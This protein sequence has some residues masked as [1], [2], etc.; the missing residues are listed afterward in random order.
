MSK[1]I[2]A[3]VK[4]LEDP[5][6]LTG[7][8]TY[9]DDLRPVPNIHHAAILRS[10]H[11]HARIL[12][13]DVSKALAMPGVVGVLTPQDVLELSDP[14]PVGVEAP[15]K[16]YATATDKVRFVG[17][18]VCVV[19]AR[20]RYIAEDARE[21]IEV[22][23]EP[24]PAV[25]DPEKAM[26]PGAPLLHEHIGSN[27]ACYRSLRYGDPDGAFARA[28]VVVSQRQVFPKYGSTPMECYGVIATY[29]PISQ[30][31]TVWSNFQGPFS[32]HPVTARALRTPENKLRFIVPPDIGGGFG[33]KSSMFPYIALIALAARKTGVPVKWIEDRLEHLAASSSNTDRVSYMEVALTRDGTILGMRMKLI[34]NVGA[35]IR[36]PDPG[37]LFRPLGNQVGPYYF[38]DLAV[39]AY[40]VHTNKSLTGPNRGYGC[41]H[42]YFNIE[43]LLDVAADRLGMDPAELRRKNLIP[44]S[45]MPYTTPTGGI[46]DAGD[47]PATFERLLEMARYD[48]LRRE[49]ARARAEGRLYGIGIALAV[50]PSVSNM[51]YVTIAFDRKV[52]QRPDY[53]PKSGAA[54]TGTVIVD[55]RGH[56]TCTLNT[57]PEGQGHETAVA[58]LIADELSIPIENVRVVADFDSGSRAWTIATGTYSSRFAAAGASAA[59]LAAR[60]VKAKMIE[61]AAHVLEAAPEDIV[62]ADG[63]FSVRGAPERAV[64]FRRVAGIAHWNPNAL[65]KGMEPGLQSTALWNFEHATAPDEYDR[66]NSS[67]LYGF[68]GEIVVVE[69]DR[70]TGQI[71]IK[72]YFTMHD[73]GRILNPMIVEGQ[74]WGAVLHGM[75]GALFEEMVYDENG[76]FLAGTFM[77]YLCPTAMEAPPLT[78]GHV[79]YPTPASLTGAKG[80]GESSSETAPAAIANAVADALKPLGIEI[81]SLPL[82]P[83]KIWALLRAAEARAGHGGR[84]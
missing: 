22:E 5:R 32:L 62:L 20:D 11:A 25:V 47:Y 14:F 76:A 71:A 73:A 50:D 13:V 40:A 9:I 29:D 30:E 37:C 48:E 12:R 45:A 75:A 55:A 28:D 17:E 77:D 67:Q 65:P 16:Y 54:E 69:V 24:L 39:E 82:T 83:S 21:L 72:N 26:E 63:V 78:I 46:Y 60:K 57:C 31:Y 66:V 44:A 53:Q 3:R 79:E 33:I 36:A 7:R 10:P 49:Q 38:K 64:P 61:I 80:V 1:W 34:D 43:R 84:Q 74:I 8:G 23:Y 19:V 27:I 2:G 18:P 51:G 59:L 81:N 41:Q 58:Q 56:V 35:Y 42:L 70:E 4:R 15:V 6:L 52:R 68:V